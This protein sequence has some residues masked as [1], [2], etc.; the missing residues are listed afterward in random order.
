MNSCMDE[1]LT[2]APASRAERVLACQGMPMDEISA[3]LAIDDPQIVRQYIELHRERLEE[4][5]ADRLRELVAVEEQL[6]EV[7]PTS[8]RD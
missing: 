2:S 5:L 6:L 1:T 7:H 8:R 4:R 3:I